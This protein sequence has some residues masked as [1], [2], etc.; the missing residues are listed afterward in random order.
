M[1]SDTVFTLGVGMKRFVAEF[2]YL[3]SV[4]LLGIAYLGLVVSGVFRVSPVHL[5]AWVRYFVVAGLFLAPAYIFR[6]RQSHRGFRLLALVV[7]F[8][9][10]LAL[11]W[12]YDQM[13]FWVWLATVIVLYVEVYWLLPRLMKRRE[14]REGTFGTGGTRHP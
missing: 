10:S 3:T 11:P 14:C 2:L 4:L 1:P 12:F 13:S 7:S 9:C 5:P 6:Q 8:G